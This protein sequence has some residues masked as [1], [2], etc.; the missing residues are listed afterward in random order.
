MIGACSPSI[1]MLKRVRSLWC[2][3][4]LAVFPRL[5]RGRWIRTHILPLFFCSSSSS[6]IVLK[7]VVADSSISRTI[8]KPPNP[9]PFMSESYSW[10]CTS[11]DE[12]LS[13]QGA[14]IDHL[15]GSHRFTWIRRPHAV[16]VADNHGHVWYCFKCLGKWGQDHRSFDSH[17]AMWDHL[18]D[19][20]DEWR[21]CLKRCDDDPAYGGEM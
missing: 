10:V 18:C 11:D 7:P 16:G 9:H 12:Y 20:H 19:K 13:T 8:T 4:L 14:A 21:D 5:D 6:F 17:R 1:D 2:L 3:A 15:R